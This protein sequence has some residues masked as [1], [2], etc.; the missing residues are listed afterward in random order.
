MSTL[1]RIIA[2][3][4]ILAMLVIGVPW[5]FEHR[6]A[7]ACV[8]A[9]NAIE[10]KAEIKNTQ[11]EATQ[12]AADKSAGDKFNA[13]TAAPVDNLPAVPAS[14]QQPACPSP[15]PHPRSNPAQGSAAPA[16]RAQAPASV[17]QP[18]W[19]TIEQSDVQS[20]HDA[21]AEVIYLQGLLLDRQKACGG[22]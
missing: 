20:G 11:V 14:L 8:K 15:V 5:Y 7:E 1:E 3:G 9:D 21:D 6:G 2:Y 13:S 16:V 10:A 4:A 18:Q 19:H 17:V 12:A 22:R